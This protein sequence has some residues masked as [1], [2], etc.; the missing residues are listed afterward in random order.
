MNEDSSVSNRIQTNPSEDLNFNDCWNKIGVHGDRSCN[1]LSAVIHC[2]ECSVY[3]AFGD[4]LLERIAPPDYLESWIGLLENS[5]DELEINSGN[6]AIADVAGAISLMIF[7]LG[8]ERFALPVRI[9]QEVTEIS[10]I[11]PLPH[12]SNQFFLGL[13]NNRGEILLCASLGHL[14]HIPQFEEKTAPANQITRSRMLVVGEDPNKWVFPV[15]QVYGIFRFYLHEL[16]AAP[17]VVTKSETSY[18]KG[19][20]DWEG[21]KVNF[22]DWELLFYRLNQQVL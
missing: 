21:Y 9:L 20:I 18:T 8:K 2:H 19:I 17:I 3:A 7:R 6:E 5:I 13:V 11:Q 16:Q 14:L 1:E 12:R 10:V 4:S 15:D 22:L